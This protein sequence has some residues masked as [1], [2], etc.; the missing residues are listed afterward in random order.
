MILRH[1]LAVRS[2]APVRPLARPP[3]PTARPFIFGAAG[4]LWPRNLEPDPGEAFQER[5]TGETLLARVPFQGSK[6]PV[7]ETGALVEFILFTFE[8]DECFNPALNQFHA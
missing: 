8:F 6:K 5:R 1:W 4:K 7:Q 3:A 2:G